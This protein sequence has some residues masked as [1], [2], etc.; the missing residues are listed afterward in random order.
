MR[1]LYCLGGGFDATFNNVNPFDR[2]HEILVIDTFDE[3]WENS[4]DIVSTGALYHR[5]IRKSYHLHIPSKDLVQR[6]H[7]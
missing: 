7:V 3:A 1:S 6:P 5:K 2:I 4:Y